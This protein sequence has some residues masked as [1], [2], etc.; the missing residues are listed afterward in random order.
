MTNEVYEKTLF[1]LKETI[2]STLFVPIHKAGI[3]FI[4]GFAVVTA[5]LSLL[6]GILA[7]TFLAL[8]LWC[9]YFFRDP[10]RAVPE[11]AS[12]VLSPADGR[13]T[14]VDAGVH[15]PVELGGEPVQGDMG[16]VDGTYTRISI[17]LSV[18]DVHVNRIP[19][20]GKIAKL[21]YKPGLY[22][23]AGNERASLENERCSAL[24]TLEDG[25]SLAFVQIA[26]LIARRILCDIKEGDMVRSGD[27][28]G[29][30][31]FGSRMDVYLP[32]G[33]APLVAVGQRA[34][35]GETVLADLAYGGSAREARPI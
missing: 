6:S 25:R 10:V 12:L 11:G 21:V 14:S 20:S 24:L 28:Y 2:V 33:V 27:R 5:F 9:V 22:L 19:L 4:I 18:F 35:G 16:Q 34:V 32:E 8:T 17:F 7:M 15:L 13:V 1:D 30:I 31:R 29:I 23:N 26:G 3:P